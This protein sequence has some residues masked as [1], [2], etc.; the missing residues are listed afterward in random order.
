MIILPLFLQQWLL[1]CQVLLQQHLLKL[2]QL[3]TESHC[4]SFFTLIPYLHNC[5]YQLCSSGRHIKNKT[6]KLKL[7]KDF[8]QLRRTVLIIKKLWV[9]VLSAFKTVCDLNGC[10]CFLNEISGV[11]R[12]TVLQQVGWKHFPFHFCFLWKKLQLCYI[13]VKSYCALLKQC[14]SLFFY[15]QTKLSSLQLKE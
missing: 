3:L 11:L 7:M 10:L 8:V 6:K 13:I 2:W 4:E 12:R 15:I 5:F 9:F 1:P 14:S